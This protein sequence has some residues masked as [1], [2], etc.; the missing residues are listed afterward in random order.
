[1]RPTDAVIAVT[2]RCNARC[3]MCGIWKVEA[4]P[5]PPPEMYRK[6]PSSLRDVNLTGGEPFLRKDLPQVHAAVRA[7]CPRAQTV[8]SSNGLLRERIVHAARE[9]TK[10]ERN[11]GIAISID[12]PAEVHDVQRGVPGAFD[13]ALA[14]VKALQ[15]AGIVNLRLAFTATAANAGRLKSVYDLAHELGVQFTCAIQHSSE[16]YF[17]SETPSQGLPL[18]ELRSQIE[19]VMSAE[20]ATASPKRWARAYFM[21][22]L[23][24]FACGRGRPLPCRAGRDFFFLDPSGQVFACNA[25]PFGMG[26]LS[27][28]SFEEIWTSAEASAARR[29]AA[30]CPAGCWMICTA[31]TAIKRRW[32]LVLAWALKRKVFGVSL[33]DP[34]A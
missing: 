22:G 16:H 2:W 7:A 19:Q 25:A 4:G 21:Q 17:H 8:V 29:K 27:A 34:P 3:E 15:D 31:R 23:Y 28:H 5:E 18:G 10:A 9:M 30:A 6:L 32:A 1:M 24:D 14:T 11:I 33:E 26:D 13:K 12:G 20:L